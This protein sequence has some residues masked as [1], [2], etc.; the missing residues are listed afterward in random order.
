MDKKRQ[1]MIAKWR[2]I[3]TGPMHPG[4]IEDLRSIDIERREDGARQVIGNM[5]R[6]QA[7]VELEADWTVDDVWDKY[8]N[9]FVESMLE[10]FQDMQ[11]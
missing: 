10:D 7:L 1:E 8:R 4:L 6:L 9:P 11:D 2:A 3:V 5:T